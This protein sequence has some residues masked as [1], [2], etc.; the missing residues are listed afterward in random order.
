MNSK[1]QLHQAPNFPSVYILLVNNY[2]LR[3]LKAK[4]LKLQ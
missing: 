2:I 3:V 1:L 4:N